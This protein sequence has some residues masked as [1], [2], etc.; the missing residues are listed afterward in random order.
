MVV[1]MMM[2]VMKRRRRS[3]SKDYWR[4]IDYRRRIDNRS[5]GRRGMGTD[6]RSNSSTGC[7]TYSRSNYGSTNRAVVT[8]MVGATSM[9]RMV[10]GGWKL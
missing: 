6:S 9:M 7:C 8:V 10:H 2:P 4:R 1:M 3:R 5:W